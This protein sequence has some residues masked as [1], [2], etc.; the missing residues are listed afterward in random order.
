MEIYR[1]EPDVD[2]FRSLLVADPIIARSDLMAFDGSSKLA[3]WPT[4]L[5]AHLDNI[6]TP[7]P[8]IL[9]IGAGNLVL[10]GRSWD[11]LKHQ[12]KE[13]CEYLPTK[14]LGGTGY[15][16]N[17]VR[18]DECLDVDATTWVFGKESGK[19]I[20]I[21]RFEFNESKVPSRLL[22]K[23]P[24]RCFELFCTER[25]KTILAEHRISGLHFVKVWSSGVES[26]AA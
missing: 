22:F 10:H 11:L 2:R 23:I 25:F 20:R 6:A 12:L 15:V 21:E 17:V 16:V 3:R 24:E 18:L 13:F 26:P 7:E 9:D 19:R 1:V 5:V 14:W 4:P 8:D